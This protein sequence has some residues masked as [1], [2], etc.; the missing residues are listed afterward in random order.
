MGGGIIGASVAYH[1]ARRGVRDV[2]VLDR[3][4]LPGAG[5]TGKATGGF[6]AQFATRINIRLSLLAREKLRAFRDE[7]GVDSG[8]TPGGYLWIAGTEAGLET[9]RAA[10]VV[11]RSEGLAE[12][13]EIDAGDVGRINP[14]VAATDIVGGAYCPTDG[15]IRP[16]DM[17]EGYLSAA[18]RLGASIEWGVEVNEIVFGKDGKA[19]ELVTSTGRVA[20]DAVVNA[21][22]PWAGSL[23]SHG[24]GEVPVVPLRRQVAVSEPSDILPREMPMT[25]FLENGFHLRVRDGRVL[26]LRPTRGA[27]ED[28]F[29][30]TVEDDWVESVRQEAV[31]RLPSLAGLPIDRAACFAGLYEMS[32]DSHAILG[33]A[34]WCDNLF[35]VNGSSGHGVM[36]APALGQLLSEIICDG[37]A[38]T[39]EVSDLRPTRF[40]ERYSNETSEIL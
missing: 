27:P 13:E 39:L 21:A 40:S 12:V 23:D 30:T 11:Q 14:A 25:I 32:P 8:Y 1:L 24:R 3:G 26:L 29:D 37:V 34:P 22:G 5:S 28:P 16:L 9:L 38:S 36:H 4:E 2:L 7:I 18:S 17:L 10:I 20:V 19:R 31:L 33:Q 35:L 15:F 6:R